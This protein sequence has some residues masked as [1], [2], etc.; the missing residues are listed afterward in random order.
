[1]ASPTYEQAVATRQIESKDKFL[2]RLRE[3]P[4]IEYACQKSGV[5]RTTYYRWRRKS[6]AF[7]QKCEEAQREGIDFINDMSESQLIQMI[8]ERKLPAISLW[9]KH[10]HKR[11]GAR[12]QGEEERSTGKPIEKAIYGGKSIRTL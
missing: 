2:A 7:A 11:Y 10:N 1:M 6:G 8:K 4:I 9:L 3:T 12:T 5:G